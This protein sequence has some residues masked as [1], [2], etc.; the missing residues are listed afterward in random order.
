MGKNTLHILDIVFLSNF[1]LSPKWR[2]K[3]QFTDVKGFDYSER[4]WIFF[5]WKLP[6]KK[7][8]FANSPFVN[9]VL[10]ERSLREE[11]EKIQKKKNIDITQSRQNLRLSLG[12][13]FAICNIFNKLNKVS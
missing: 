7:N 2:R 11:E 13:P 4:L 6:C 5:G 3:N 10:C 8:I 9:E 1:Y 12:Q